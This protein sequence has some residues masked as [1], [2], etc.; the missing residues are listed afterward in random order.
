M[1]ASGIMTLPWS[2]PSGTGAQAAGKGV[3]RKRL[4]MAQHPEATEMGALGGTGQD[5]H[6]GPG[7]W[8]MGRKGFAE[9]GRAQRPPGEAGTI[10]TGALCASQRW[11]DR[12]GV[13]R[14][15]GRS[16]PEGLWDPKGRDLHQSRS[17]DGGTGKGGLNAH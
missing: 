15:Q 17:R 12:R 10:E 8:H 3:S 7:L 5:R 2:P 11:D 13:G 6:G 14:Q 9:L 1:W 16:A 4:E